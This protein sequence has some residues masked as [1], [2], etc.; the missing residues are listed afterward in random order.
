MDWYKCY[1][2]HYNND[3]NTGNTMNKK[4]LQ[5]LSLTISS[6]ILL[7]LLWVSLYRGTFVLNDWIVVSFD[8][9]SKI[10]IELIIIKNE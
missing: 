5:F 6:L 1:S 2:V 4:G 8:L 9:I 3:I 10:I 7:Y